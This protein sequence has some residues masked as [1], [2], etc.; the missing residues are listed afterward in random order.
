MRYAQHGLAAVTRDERWVAYQSTESGRWEVY[1]ATFPFFSNRRQVSA[2]GGCQP[3]WRGDGK[4]LFYLT[5]D[6]RFSSV[7]VNPQTGLPV[8]CAP[9]LVPSAD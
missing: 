4:E 7:A 2:S 9:R 6:G 3:L 8:A 5:L 1:V